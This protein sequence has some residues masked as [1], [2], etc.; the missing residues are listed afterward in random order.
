MST[1]AI[2][3]ETRGKIICFSSMHLLSGKDLNSAELET[4][5]VSRNPTTLITASGDVQIHE[6]ATVYVYDLGLFVTVQI[7]EGTPAVLSLGKLCEEHGYSYEWGSGQKPQL[8]TNG[9]ESCATLRT[10]CTDRCPRIVD[11]F[12]Q[13]ECKY[14][15]YIVTAG[16]V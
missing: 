4:V 14:V 10:L 3:I 6:E 9:K 12:V 7:L 5:R 16:H 1:S 2:L 13:L 15:F 8:T 11:R